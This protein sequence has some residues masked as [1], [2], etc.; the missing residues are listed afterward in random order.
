[1]SWT[2][3]SIL[4][5]AALAF[6]L[7]ILALVRESKSFANLAFVLGIA[8]FGCET[9]CIAFQFSSAQIIDLETWQT[10]RLMIMAALPGVWLAFS[11]S[12]SRGNYRDFL[13]K[14]KWVILAVFGIPLCL[15]FIF[16]DEFIRVAETPPPASVIF[17]Y[18]LPAGKVIVGFFLMSAVLV[19]MN[20]ERTFMASVGTMRWRIKF[21]VIGLGLLFAMRLYSCSQSLL[22]SSFSS[23]LAIM[24]AYMIGLAS[25]MM[26]VSLFRS[27]LSE[28]EIYPSL[29]VL[30]GSITAL[31]AGVY[32]LC[33]GV[34]ARL[35]S[36]FGGDTSFPI[37]AFVI[38]VAITGLAVLLVSDRIQQKTRL[39]V[40]RHFN[41]PHYD[42]RKVWAAF[43]ESSASL[44][45]KPEFCRTV[46]RQISQTFNSLSVNI[47]LLD[48]RL[49]KLTFA[50]STLLTGDV[51]SQELSKHS[52]TSELVEGLRLH[53]NPI[54][55]E[56]AT[57][58]WMADLRQWNPNFFKKGHQRVC[59]PLV[60]NQ[61][62]QGM[63]ILGDRVNGVK[64][65]VE[66]LD[67]LKCIGDQI[68]A[69]LRNLKLSE[70]IARSRELE[71]FQAM[72]TFVVHDLKNIAY[73]LS[74]MLQN[75]RVHFDNPDFRADAMSNLARNVEHLNDL[76]SR[77]NL[78]RQ[79][80]KLN[81]RESDLNEVVIDTMKT[82]ETPNGIRVVKNLSPLPR[83]AFDSAQI[84]KVITNL[85]INARDAIGSQGEIHVQ[86]TTQPGGVQL[87]VSD[88]GCGMSPEFI[89]RQLF[90]PFQST[91][92]KGLG[93][94]MFH[95][96]SIVDA[97]QG[98]IEIESA[99]QKGTTFHIFLP[100][101]PKSSVGAEGMAMSSG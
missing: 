101:N 4:L 27:R 9:I 84:H 68:A 98:R 100:L 81:L 73:T 20:L 5:C 58:L 22:Y 29:T 91:K 74:L 70:E 49:H 62:L 40:S 37:K 56:S 71:A 61:E 76:V 34:L 69:A 48:E 63:I 12:Y 50:A 1:M 95:S 96:K 45:N 51:A 46:V 44:M 53:P 31:L 36:L 80:L 54:D 60:S 67:L 86:T 75:M 41:R 78:L 82:L 30:Q 79:G 42:Y 66:D 23:S 87:T 52:C 17:L 93:I 11:L 94:G 15:V 57:E 25:L 47:W 64:F 38:M 88:N 32:L 90:K 65:A 3:A 92:K 59:L 13:R 10:N 6:V 7:A 2:F 28:I 97:H 18:L 83:F 99:L 26:G 24:D 43:T 33:M 21:L 55:L 19:V 77:F 8:L 35:A 89:E 72:S 85:I 14:W 39:F 16:H